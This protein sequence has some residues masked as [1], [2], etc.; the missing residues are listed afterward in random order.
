M[1]VNKYHFSNLYI[2]EQNM[3]IYNEIIRKKHLKQSNIKDLFLLNLFISNEFYPLLN[4][5]ETLFRYKVHE[6]LSEVYQTPNWFNQIEWETIQL[7]T[8]KDIVAKKKKI[9]NPSYIVDDLSFGFLW[10]L[11]DSQYKDSIFLPALIHLFPNYNLQEPLTRSKL[12]SIF[13][14]LVYYRNDIAHCNVIIHEEHKL[15]KSYNKALQLLYWLDKDYFNLFAKQKRFF[16][17]HRILTTSSY[18][19]VGYGYYWKHIIL[20]FITKIWWKI[21]RRY[22][23]FFHLEEE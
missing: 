13:E 4:V 11:F 5:I 2:S 22:P 10:H 19:I 7:N 21:K 9:K 6:K 14:L 17:L 12:K 8:L 3:L 23:D 15:I 16:K 1:N 20:R 18:S